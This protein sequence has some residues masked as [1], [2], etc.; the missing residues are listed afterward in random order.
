MRRLILLSCFW[1]LWA[2]APAFANPTVEPIDEAPAPTVDATEEPSAAAPAAGDGSPGS[3]AGADAAPPAADAAAAG[4]A[5]PPSGDAAALPSEDEAR[6]QMLAAFAMSDEDRA[7]YAVALRQVVAQ[8][9]GKVMD[10]ITAKI[11]QKQESKLDNFAL[12]LSL[13]ALCGVF[14]LGLPLVLRKKYPGKGGP[15]FKYSALAALLFFLAVNLF[16]VV[17]FVMRGAQG[18]LGEHTNPQVQIVES[19]F[20]LFADKADDLALIGPTLVEPTLASLTGESEE[21]VVTQMLANAQRLKQDFTAFSK[22][23]A[24]FKKVD[25]LFGMLPLIL[26][27]V[28]LFLFAK[29]ARPTLTEI[30]KL[31]ERAVSGAEGVV[32]QTVK[33]TLR[34]VWAEA[35]AA[36]AAVGLLVGLTLVA[37]V[38]LGLVLQP[39]LEVFIAYLTLALLY[40]QL[41]PEASTF[42][43][44]FSLTASMLFLVLNLAVVVLSSAFFL[45]K[46]QRIFQAKFREGVPLGQHKRF[47]TWGSLGAVWAQVLPVL[48][49]LVAVKGIGW[50]VEKSMDRYFNA[51]NPAA[52][53]WGFLLASGPAMFLVTFGL[54]FWAARGVKALAYLAK[55]RV[56][57]AVTPELA[58]ARHAA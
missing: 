41:S 33:L 52:S 47:W 28:G 22:V 12:A 58:Y 51:E 8:V 14:L 37:S 9:R 46:A 34:N 56:P 44:L 35:K 25:W 55:Y 4:D 21:P 57:P 36:F 42:W 18:V 54:V 24:V 49:I 50:L 26:I 16:A 5:A 23:G 6:M 38:L 45:G 7:K 43:V 39:A 32:K 40:V 10:K 11:A 53:S 17:L 29:V 27:G 15:L 20:D 19:T 30:V 48:Y 1:L 3:V 13:F 31:P 2:A